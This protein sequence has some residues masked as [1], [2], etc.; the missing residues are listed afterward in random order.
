MIPIP[1][2]QPDSD[3]P[4]DLGALFAMAY[5]RGR[6]I[7]LLDYS[8]AALER[9]GRRGSRP[10]AADRERPLGDRPNGRDGTAV[11]LL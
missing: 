7:D 1:L 3:V 10:G 5:D 2:L 11:P 9:E 8:G 4:P 6:C